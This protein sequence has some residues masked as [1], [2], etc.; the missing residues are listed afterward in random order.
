MFGVEYGKICADYAGCLT[1]AQYDEC[2]KKMMDLAKEKKM[3][4]KDIKKLQKYIF[5]DE[6]RTFLFSY[7]CKHSKN[8]NT[9]SQA[10]EI[11]N[12]VAKG[13]SPTGFGLFVPYY[14][15]VLLLV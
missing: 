2:E 6:E 4:K 10:G 12:K 11:L 7:H 15:L 13:R 3:K 5:D 1:Q 8:G 9:T 14:S